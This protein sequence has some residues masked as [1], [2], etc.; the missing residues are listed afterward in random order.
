MALKRKSII[1]YLIAL[2]VVVVAAVAGGI[3]AKADPQTWD[4]MA[5]TEWYISTN[6]TFKIDSEDKL[7]GVAKLVNEG[8]GN[9]LQG[10]ILEITRDMDLKNYQWIPIGT[11]EHPFK[12][13]L[14]TEGGLIKKISN[15]NV[16]TNLSYQGLVGNMEGGTV[17]GL[18]FEE[19]GSITVTG[20]TYDVYAGSAV[21][22]MSGSSIVF[23]ITNNIS[24]STHASPYRSFTGGIVGMG[25][26][27]ISN[28]INN[29]TIT[30]Q[31]SADIGG[32]LGYGE[33]RGIIIKK[34]VNNA[35][36]LAQGT[37]SAVLTAGGIAGH[38]TGPLSLN[39]EDTPIINNAS[40]TIAGG[41]RV[42]AGG[43]AGKVDNT[44]VFSNM[45]TN[46]GAVTVNATAAEGSAAGALV[47]A[48]GTVVS[49]EV[50]ITF[51][52]TAPVVNN[53]GKNVYTG[54]IAGYT[55]SK[56]TWTHAY[57]NT[58]PITATGAQNVSTGGFV[59][60]AAGGLVTSNAAAGVFE[61]KA[62][63]SVNGG[64]GI[65][66]GG[67]AGYDA[68]G[69]IGQASSTGALNV[70]GTADVYTGGIVGYEAGGTITSSV[71]GKTASDLLAITSDGT[72][73]GIAGYLEGTLNDSSVKYATLQV[74]S[75]GGIAGG[76]PVMHKEP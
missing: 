40:V 31:G 3:M 24:I 59:G 26:G 76:L 71:T 10:K 43:I 45:T 46:K 72:I 7:A 69:N 65:Y 13:T 4:S 63:V 60:H 33:S 28:S 49:P 52:N 29:G 51:V 57:I 20:V 12:G 55:G 44:V 41:N 36:I 23:D 32:I 34:V 14:I 54:G 2:A 39:D 1:G 61:N 21:G 9:G 16:V 42:V 50:G 35:A 70:K 47:G 19:S 5:K 30:A 56:F 58:Q 17:G 53:G 8:T 68:G 18:T 27:M 73:G 25:E 62:L 38:T 48:T 64:T 75:A 11:A 37:D 74:T 6:D 22:K 66:T 15:M 67:I